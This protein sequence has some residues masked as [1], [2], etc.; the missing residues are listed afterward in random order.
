[1]RI[2]L[3]SF[4]D[5]VNWPRTHQYSVARWQ[6]KNLGRRWPELQ[7]LSARDSTGNPLRNLA[8]NVFRKKYE[9]RLAGVGGTTLHMLLERHLADAP[10]EDLALLCWCNPSRPKQHE[11]LYCHRILI[12]YWIEEH[13]PD[14]E[15]VYADGAEN[16]V[17]EREQ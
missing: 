1:M 4:R 12:G 3:T 8:P 9:D 13:F 17:W 7:E 10:N 15:V 6:P 5:S 14:I 11:K 2:I 16:P